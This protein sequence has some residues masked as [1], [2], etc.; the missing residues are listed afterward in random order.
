M[1]IFELENIYNGIIYIQSTVLGAAMLSLTLKARK[2]RKRSI[3]LW[4]F[5]AAFAFL[6]GILSRFAVSQAGGLIMEA[7]SGIEEMWK[8]QMCYSL[9]SVMN[10]LE[11]S[12]A[13]VILGISA[14]W[15]CEGRKN[16][17][18]FVS[19]LFMVL[20]SS[21]F[22]VFKQIMYGLFS[23]GIDEFSLSRIPPHYGMRLLID[24]IGLA[25]LF[26]VYRYFF[27][28]KLVHILEIAE[29]QICQIVLVPAMS[30]LL[31]L[32]VRYMLDSY[33]ITLLSIDP[34]SFL[35]ALVI[36]I[37]LLAIYLLMFWSIFR[38][39]L[40]SA[41]SAKVKAELDV[42]SKIQ[43]SALPTSFDIG[44]E[45]GV[46]IF[47]NMHPAKE[48]G[49]DFYDFF[50]VDEDHLAVLIADVSG[51][52]VPAALFM[53]GGRAMIRNQL[54]LGLD[55]S[56]ILKRSNNELAE[57]NKEGM[58]ITAFLGILDV[59]SGH[60][61]YSNAGHNVP[62]ICHENGVVEPVAVHHGFV[63]A[64][65][66]NIRYRR[67][68]M[69]L[70]PGDKLV[71]YTDGVTEA[72]NAAYDMYEEK[73]LTEVLEQSVNEDVEQ[74]VHTVSESIDRFVDGAEQA[75]DI[76]MVILKWNQKAQGQAQ[77]G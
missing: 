65:M 33:G 24:C 22:Y 15:I 4:S 12:V 2:G 69:D 36:I 32:T 63:L 48:V 45:K 46:D 25:V 43:L 66:K 1:E 40:A 10:V 68:E 28:E 76:T 53:M 55:P 34:G 18:I 59:K 26:A 74:T 27:R 70:F 67:Q 75:D 14:V 54:L 13:A 37:C 23:T 58:F 8:V 62:F 11:G 41:S 16:I 61:S 5:V 60:F 73:R 3:L 20:F 51:K 30:Y 19:I 71:L 7:A 39:I 42:A 56:E 31:F 77:A 72:T 38:A 29:E 47:A 50:F 49:G 17:K 35:M 21:V 44:K 52:G 57:N 9:V 64:G 6:V